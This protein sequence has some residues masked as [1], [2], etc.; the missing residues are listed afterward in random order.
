MKTVVRDLNTMGNIMDQ[1]DHDLQKDGQPEMDEEI[2]RL[3]EKKRFTF[4][5]IATPVDPLR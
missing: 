4:D 3:A 2:K 1:K 5:I